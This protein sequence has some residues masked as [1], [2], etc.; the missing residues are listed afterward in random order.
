MTSLKNKAIKPGQIKAP[1]R[2]LK[3]IE[4]TT[5]ILKALSFPKKKKKKSKDFFE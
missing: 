2:M 5:E 1:I 3:N 4:K